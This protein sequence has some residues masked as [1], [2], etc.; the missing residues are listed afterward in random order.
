M[1]IVYERDHSVAESIE[2]GQCNNTLTVISSSAKQGNT[3]V[4]VAEK[5]KEK[6]GK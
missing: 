5:E 4:G 6:R 3:S 2:S 1:V